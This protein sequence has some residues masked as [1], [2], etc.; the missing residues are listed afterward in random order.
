MLERHAPQVVDELSL[1]RRLV[2]HV[3]HDA[4]PHLVEP[5][6]HDHRQIGQPGEQLLVDVGDRVDECSGTL[7]LPVEV[8]HGLRPLG[9]HAPFSSARRKYSTAIHSRM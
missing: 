6:V 2:G 5:L 3:D 4:G 8:A 1:G 9:H 7:R